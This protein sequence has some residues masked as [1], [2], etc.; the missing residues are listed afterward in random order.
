MVT[1]TIISKQ[2]ISMDNLAKLA[3]I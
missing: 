1:C 2:H 3:P